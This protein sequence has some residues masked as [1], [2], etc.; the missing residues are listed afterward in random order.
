NIIVESGASFRT[1][2]GGTD[3]TF[4]FAN[5][6]IKS[7]G[8]FGNIDGNVNETGNLHFNVESI[9]TD[10]TITYNANGTSTLYQYFAKKVG[11]N[12][13]ISGQGTVNVI[14]EAADSNNDHRFILRN[15]GNTF[16]GVYNLASANKST[17]ELATS[18]TVD[19]NG[20]VTGGVSKGA[21]FILGNTNSNLVISAS[22]VTIAG[23]EGVGAVASE[24]TGSHTLTINQTTG[25]KILSGA[26]T[27]ATGGTLGIIKTGDG[28]LTLSGNNTYSG[29]ITLNGG[30][31]IAGSATAFGTAAGVITATKGTLDLGGFSMAHNINIAYGTLKNAA[32]ATGNV[33]VKQTAGTGSI[34]SL[35]GM[36]GTH[37]KEVIGTA[38]TGTPGNLDEATKITDIGNGAISLGATQLGVSADMIGYTGHQATGQA[39]SFIN[40]TA[41][42]TLTIA[43]N[44]SLTLTDAAATT[45]IDSTDSNVLIH[46]VN[47]GLTFTGDFS[48]NTPYNILNEMFQYS[49]S[50]NH[51]QTGSI[52]LTA[53][54]PTKLGYLIIKTTD[55]INV[56]TPGEKT[57]IEAVKGIMNNGVLNI[58]AVGTSINV[59]GL[60]G[61]SAAALIKTGTNKDLVVTL[62]NSNSHVASSTYKGSIDGSAA[63]VKGGTDYDM[64]IGGFVNASQLTVNNGK[65]TIG[66]NLTISNA[67]GATGNVTI[68]TGT[69]LTLNGKTNTIAGTLSL[70][71][72][73]ALTLGE[74]ST[75][76]ANSLASA[77]GTTITLGKDA[78]LSVTTS[79]PLAA[80]I[81]GAGTFSI[82]NGAFSL[83]NGGSIGDDT[84]LSLGQNATMSVTNAGMSLG[85]LAGKGS[86]TMST[87]GTLT[88]QNATSTFSGSLTGNGTINHAGTGT[89]TL[90]TLGNANINLTQSGTGTIILQ[91][92]ATPD[93]QISYKD[94]QVSSGKLQVANN[95]TVTNII[96]GKDAQVI[97]GRDKDAEGVYQNSA[98]LTSTHSTLTGGGSITLGGIT[99]AN[100]NTPLFN[101]GAVTKTGDG[102]FTFNAGTT[103][104]WTELE[105]TID[106]MAGTNINA[107]DYEATL[108]GSLKNLGYEISSITTN[109]DGT[110]Q[111][112]VSSSGKNGFLNYANSANTTAAAN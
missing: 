61:T 97:L 70:D 68:G 64:N 16:N 67:D 85:G 10:G 28:T 101:A 20:I 102:A 86:V 83:G 55:V 9:G 77:N 75:T 53:V 54:D 82:A 92:T 73:G 95:T 103:G 104:D 1:H 98:I 26:V 34:V 87:G 112:N 89:Q 24:G 21:S 23:V 6:Y 12:G 17:I 63:L 31:L 27:Q 107:A 48:F 46:L 15:A 19:A 80:G 59:Q 93:Q 33:T 72:T 11:L 65:L 18:D 7:G 78:T 106:L 22:A 39:L 37:L 58:G 109:A 91:N 32:N 76:S 42:N 108:L 100:A 69:T 66:G 105:Y 49:Q 43:G 2:L 60:E 62:T 111:L 79:S 14:A 50:Q 96:I 51:L 38:T 90:D 8:S 47:G 45:L 44:L 41:T 13:I 35:A 94:V 5:A 99:A 52:S 25:N 3:K 29:G 4:N 81:T 57:A 30:S 40:T 56:N 110:L 36:S 88:L 84:T 74:G 71:G